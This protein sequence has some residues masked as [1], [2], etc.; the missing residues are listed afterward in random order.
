M[1]LANGYLYTGSRD[2]T[3][4]VWNLQRETFWSFP[5]SHTDSSINYNDKQSYYNSYSNSSTPYKYGDN[6]NLLNSVTP[7]Y[8]PPQP[9]AQQT[10]QQTTQHSAHKNLTLKAQEAVENTEKYEKEIKELSPERPLINQKY[11]F[12]LKPNSEQSQTPQP[13]YSP[14]VNTSYG[15]T[16]PASSSKKLIQY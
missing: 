4:K 5:P 6:S 3:I 14:Q 15:V 11:L 16:Q 13:Q 10:Q 8:I 9:P 1:E 2:Q 12:L 7:F